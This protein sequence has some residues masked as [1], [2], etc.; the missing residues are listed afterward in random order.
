M[1]QRLDVAALRHGGRRSPAGH[2]DPRCRTSELDRIER[3]KSIGKGRR[4][5]TDKRVPRACR[6]D[7]R[8]GCNGRN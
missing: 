1:Q 2:G 8:P 7:D 6:I 3:G 4:K 5:A